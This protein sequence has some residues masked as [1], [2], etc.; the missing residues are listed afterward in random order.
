VGYQLF[1]SPSPLQS[2]PKQRKNT[3]LSLPAVK[4]EKSVSYQR[5]KFGDIC[6]RK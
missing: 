2:P 1:T 6:I 5:R 4:L 3:S